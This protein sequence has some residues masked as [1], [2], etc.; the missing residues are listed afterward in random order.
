MNYARRGVDTAEGVAANAQVDVGRAR[1]R[2]LLRPGHN[3][4][5]LT[6]LQ[7]VAR[8]QHC[9]PIG[10]GSRTHVARRNVV[11]SLEFAERGRE[12]PRCDIRQNTAREGMTAYQYVG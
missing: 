9:A 3:A 5:R 7:L 1:C 4:V 8:H 6:D 10:G 11:A 12:A 2:A